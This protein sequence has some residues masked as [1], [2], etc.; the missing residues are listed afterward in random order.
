[1]KF[2]EHNEKVM[3]KFASMIISRMKQMKAGD[4]K[5]GWL[6]HDI[7]GSPMSISARPYAGVNVLMLLMDTSMRG[8][9]YPIYCTL[10]QAN[11][12]GGHVNKGE[13]S[14]PVIF[15]KFEIKDPAGRRISEEDYK[16]MSPTQKALCTVIPVLKSYN[17]FNIQQTNLAEVCPQKLDELTAKYMGTSRTDTRGMYANA[18]IDKMLHDQTW[19]C[20]IIYDQEANGACYSPLKDKITVPRKSQFKIHTKAEDV[21]VDGQEFYST[22]VHEMI[23]STG[24]ESR[25]NRGKGNRFGDKLYAKE[26]LVAELGAAR[27]GQELGFNARILNNNAAYLDGWIN[28]LQEEPKYVLTL[29][30]DVD[31]ASRM[32]LDTLAA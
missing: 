9:T 2:T 4:W 14:M 21:Y 27:I 15:W 3:E 7:T 6:G 8:Y 23:H 20:P 29:L 28:A 19:V 30:G 22:L 25:L 24:T 31:K 1:M 32:I 26:E 12:L 5:Q 13:K 11:L 17:V 18:A 10:K 16:L